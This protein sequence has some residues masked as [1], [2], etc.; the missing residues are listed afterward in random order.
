MVTSLKQ[1]ITIDELTSNLPDA[2]GNFLKY[3]RRLEFEEEPNYDHCRQ[4]FEDCLSKRGFIHDHFYDWLVKKTGNKI[5]EKDYYDS[6]ESLL[7][8]D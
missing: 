2:F 4:L 7:S 5:N 6:K 8:K 3:C 1:N